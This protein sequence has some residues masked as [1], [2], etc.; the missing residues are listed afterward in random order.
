[1]QKIAL[2]LGSLV[3]S[4]S[5]AQAEPSQKDHLPENTFIGLTF[6]NVRDDVLK[7]GDK[8]LYAINTSNLVQYFEWL[9]QSKWHPISLKEIMHAK[10]SGQPLPEN[11]VVISF[12]DGALSGY[13]HVYPLLKQY[14]IP[15]VFAIV[16]S[17]TNGNTQAPYE[18]YGQGNLMSWAQ[19]REMQQSEWVEFASHSDDLHKGILANPQNNQEPAALTHQY[20]PLEKRYET[21]QEYQQ[22][23][24]QDLVKSKAVLKKELGIDTLAVIWPYGAVS[25]QVERIAEQAGYPLSFSLG[26]DSLNHKDDGTFQRGLIMNNPSAEDIRQ[27]MTEF[28][29]Y[30]HLANFEPV[31]SMGLDLKQ[32]EANSIDEGNQKLGLALNQISAVANN[33]LIVNVLADENQD[34]VYEHAYFPTQHL[35]VA[36]DLL[37]RVAWQARTRVF[38]RVTA[39]LP[40]YPDPKQPLLVL[41][42]A[43]DLVKNNKG[44]DGIMLNADD[45][46]QCL[47]EQPTNT[48]TQTLSDPC[49][50]QL[51]QLFEL[52]KGIHQRTNPYLNISNHQKFSIQ[53]NVQPSKNIAVQQAVTQLQK[54][55]SLIN[56]EIDSIHQPQ[57]FQSFVKNVEKLNQT[58][59]AMVMVTLN[60]HQLKDRQQWQQ[61]QKDLLR[62]Q[63]VGVQKIGISEYS[64]NNA[65]NIHQYLYKP[66]SLN[67]SPLLYRDPF[68]IELKQEVKA[69]I[70]SDTKPNVTPDINQGVKP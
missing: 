25:P 15:A 14:K 66:M 47:L 11:S 41:D 2:F 17:W 49:Q 29:N 60:N 42:L 31:R 7:Q 39:K 43:E 63:S 38:N 32:L 68:R 20:F 65:L 69:D 33:A 58:D 24:F 30:Q 19:M 5:M 56:F 54:N 57:L 40:F 4:V 34:G 51:N 10:Q 61:L 48:Q 27:Q 59:K 70:K 52:S 21:D 6:H 36:Q 37:N 18:A 44:I 53:L 35:T 8:D 46:L 26:I 13:T 55:Y 12:D 1:M 22:R 50:Q 23:I 67:P 45:R 64:F 9:K 62:L 16:T 28:V 3:M